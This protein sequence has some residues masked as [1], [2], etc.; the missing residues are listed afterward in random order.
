MLNELEKAHIYIDRL[1]EKAKEQKAALA[2]KDQRLAE[3]EQRLARLE[4]LLAA[5]P[6]ADD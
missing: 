1:N 4:T 5:R 2:E 3:V 6:R